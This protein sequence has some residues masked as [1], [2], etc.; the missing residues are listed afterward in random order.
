MIGY[1]NRY[2]SYYV[3]DKQKRNY[4]VLGLTVVW[5]LI[6]LGAGLW[7]AISGSLSA[8]AS[9]V[10][11]QDLNSKLDSKLTQLVDAKKIYAAQEANRSLL[12][13]AI[14]D[15][16]KMVTFANEVDLLAVSHGLVFGGIEYKGPDFGA[17][18]SDTAT[19]EPAPTGE[20]EADSGGPIAVTTGGGTLG[21]EVSFEISVI[22][23]YANIRKFV[24]QLE[25]LPRFVR[26]D[27]VGISKQDVVG[28]NTET[29][30]D[31]TQL[32]IFAVTG[33]RLTATMHGAVYYGGKK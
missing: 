33:S 26:L 13:T 8:R 7:P 9:L 25:L 32:E 27:D 29:A 11:V 3:R 14:P 1:F 4:L 18:T 24:D 10:E 30:V 20:A 5:V 28:I 12:E 17:D 15:A 16:P 2:T 21:G 23:E 6:L 22:G 31:G 19:P